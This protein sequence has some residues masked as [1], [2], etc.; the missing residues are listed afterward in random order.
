VLEALKGIDTSGTTALKDIGE[1]HIG[2]ALTFI[3]MVTGA[4]RI[5]TKKGDTMLV[6]TLEDAEKSIEMV[7]FPRVFEQHQALLEATDP[8]LR[9]GAK[10]DNRRDTLQLVVESCAEVRALPS[11]EE[12]ADAAPV[13]AVQPEMDIE[14]VASWEDATP[15]PAEAAPV[16]EDAAQPAAPPAPEPEPEAEA[17]AEPLAEEDAPP[18]EAAPTAIPTT[19][20]PVRAIRSQTRVSLPSSTASSGDTPPPPNGNGSGHGNGNGNGGSEEDAGSGRVLRLYLPHTDDLQADTR[21]MQD[22]DE[23][24]R[25]HEHEH[26]DAIHLYIPNGVGTVV[27]RPCYQVRTTEALLSELGAY[28]GEESVEL[29]NEPPR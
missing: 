27:L 11:E 14:D 28:L 12:P 3:G 15:P 23:L 1:D 6:A 17:E 19:A 4:R 18:T 10:V 21:R 16:A 5:A 20:G 13:A 8:V 7:V 22:V 9:I 25:A 2:Q 24:L 26:E 29:V